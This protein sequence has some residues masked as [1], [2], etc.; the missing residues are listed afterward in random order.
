MTRSGC[1]TDSGRID[2]VPGG[3]RLRVQSQ[4]TITQKQQE[5]GQPRSGQQEEN[6]RDRLAREVSE[7][8]RRHG[9]TIAVAESLTGGM[10][11]SALAASEAA[12]EWFR[13]SLVAYS[14]EV[15]H[16]VLDVPD[17]P[18]V[19]AE[20]ATAMA[21]GVRRLL[22]ADVA[23]AVT[24]AGGPDPQDGQDPGTVYVGV[25]DGA[26]GRVH[27]LDLDGDPEDII[28]QAAD[29]TLGELLDAL[30]ARG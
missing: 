24:G 23:V 18:V 22:G 11:A 14:S 13:G 20:A 26:D 16:E 17:G 5:S 25:D 21:R 30:R 15:K 3:Y 19:S 1:A 9:V 27:E 28:V 8:A 12:S 7:L 4:S 29:G 2:G 10:V 6:T